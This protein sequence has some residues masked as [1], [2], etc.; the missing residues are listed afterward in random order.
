MAIAAVV[1][2]AV[3]AMVLLATGSG[4]GGGGHVGSGIVVKLLIKLCDQQRTEVKRK[5]QR[6]QYSISLRDAAW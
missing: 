1:T 2:D 6:E 5:I 3:Q 4:G